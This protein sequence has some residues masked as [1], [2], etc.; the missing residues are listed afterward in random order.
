MFQWAPSALVRHQQWWVG[1]PAMRSA[2]A[3]GRKADFHFALVGLGRRSTSTGGSSRSAPRAPSG[4][5]A[6]VEDVRGPLEVG[7]RMSKQRCG[8]CQTQGRV[9]VVCHDVA[10]GTWVRSC[11]WIHTSALR[12]LCGPSE[13]EFFPNSTSAST[14]SRYVN[15]GGAIGML[16][17]MLALYNSLLLGSPDCAHG[18]A[19]DQCLFANFAR[20]QALS[21]SSPGAGSELL[22]RDGDR[23]IWLRHVGRRF[24]LAPCRKLLSR[25]RSM[26]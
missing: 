21:S 9:E 13:A 24:R 26:A 4:E 14:S 2:E 8:W 17:A 23:L 7:E 22:R 20:F 18:W 15:A 10:S 16:P 11:T 19:D 6:S 12:P 3:E 1:G 25:L 5:L